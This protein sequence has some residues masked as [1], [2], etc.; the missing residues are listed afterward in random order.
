MKTQT[1][2]ALV[3]ALSAASTTIHASG[4]WDVDFSV[5]GVY[6]EPK[7]NIRASAV[8]DDG[9]G[10]Q[11]FLGGY[12]RFD[13]MGEPYTV[14]GV[15]PYLG[16]WD[17]REWQP[18]QAETDKPISGL[19]VFDDGSGPALY[20]GGE[21]TRA[22]ELTVDRIARWD[23]HAWSAIGSPGVMVLGPIGCM[24][25]FDDGTGSALYVGGSAA[26]NSPAP[27]QGIARWNGTQW[28]TVGNGSVKG[29][30]LAFA[31]YDAQDGRG[32]RLYA[33]G[34]LSL[35]GGQPVNRIAAWD[36]TAWQGVGGGVN[37]SVQAL[38]VY[39]GPDGPELIVGGSFTKAGEA[40]HAN[41]IARWNGHQWSTLGEGMSGGISYYGP[42]VR[43]LLVLDAE[44]GPS[45]FAAGVFQ[46]AGGQPARAVARWDGE[47]WHSTGMA[48]ENWCVHL[49]ALPS[50][51]GPRVAAFGVLHEI[52]GQ[53]GAFECAV[54]DDDGW[55][56]LGDGLEAGSWAHVSDILEVPAGDQ[57]SL[58]AAGYFDYA[59]GAP[60]RGIA[61]WDGATWSPI[62][63]GIYSGEIYA[64]ERFN[65][66]LIAG[67]V[68]EYMGWEF[69]GSIA[70]WDGRAWLSVGGGLHRSS[71]PGWGLA[72][73]YALA[74]YDDGSGP[75]LYAGGRF[76]DACCDAYQGLFP[77]TN[78]ARWDGRTWSD[79]AGDVSGTVR[80]LHVH[81]DGRGAA[82]NGLRRWDGKE[83][84]FVYVPPYASGTSFTVYALQSFND[85]SGPALFAGG[86]FTEVDGIA[87]SNIARWDGVT[88]SPL[89]SGI[90]GAVTSMTVHDEGCGPALFVGGHFSWA[91][92]V[93]AKGV[94]RWDGRAWSA[95]NGQITT[96]DAYGWVAALTSVQDAPP[97]LRGLYLGGRFDMFGAEADRH[98]ARWIASCTSGDLD[99][100]GAVGPS[101]ITLLLAAWGDCEAG[102]PCA[103]D[104][105]GDGVVNGLDLAH[106]LAA[107]TP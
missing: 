22:G 98:I 20:V 101:D 78:L 65:G 26:L 23:G 3:A 47:Q 37:G 72:E 19:A 40:A 63:A 93:F 21:F 88:W 104:L 80:A 89:G 16:V 85:G 10:P 76:D 17:G 6:G 79:A 11:L 106:L 58:I 34:T 87:A 61:A 84:T 39:P 94:A 64:L 90:N 68:I 73:V 86:G 77:V 91:G 49:A 27:L 4:Q 56:I 31:S 33:G 28:G 57:T 54:L 9:D 44:A 2:A 95:L 105:N 92:G 35:V 74:V 99:G 41:R 38:A 97:Q 30:V 53:P 45:L 83:Q 14:G 12:H 82:H 36:G 67:G 32:P 7:P 15:Y 29:G 48:D 69:V 46:S 75:A 96:T 55:S 103:A 59:D 107:W 71:G 51:A 50:E 5:P 52:D 62:G 43:S 81:D 100:D 1:L 102:Q 42:I 24:T 66:E 60:I 18:T 8:F 25:V 70:A 13:S